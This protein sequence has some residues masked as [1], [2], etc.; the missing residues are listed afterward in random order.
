MLHAF[1]AYESRRKAD[2]AKPFAR[3]INSIQLYTDG[4]R[5]FVVTVMWDSERPDNPIPARWTGG[6]PSPSGTGSSRS[7][8]RA[9]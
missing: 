8:T 7:K 3:G 9:P 1:S 5:W 4:S 2:D 6:A